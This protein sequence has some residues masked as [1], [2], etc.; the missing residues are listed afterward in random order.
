MGVGRSPLPGPPDAAT[1]GT[2]GVAGDGLEPV[3]L[4]LLDVQV[5]D[6]GLSDPDGAHVDALPKRKG[7]VGRAGPRPPPWGMVT[8]RPLAA[9]GPRRIGVGCRGVVGV[10]GADTEKDNGIIIRSK[11]N[12]TLFHRKWDTLVTFVMQLLLACRRRDDFDDDGQLDSIAPL[13]RS[14]PTARHRRNH[15]QFFMT[16]MSIVSSLNIMINGEKT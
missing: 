2:D 14:N 11:C 6:V 13:A 3:G 8:V 12:C 16:K 5:D 4:R 1:V 15:L 9:V 7:G 10:G